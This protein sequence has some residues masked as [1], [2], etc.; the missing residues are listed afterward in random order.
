MDVDLDDARVLLRDD[1]VEDPRRFYDELRRR[2]PVWQVPGQDSYLVADPALIR[3]AVARTEEFSSNLVSLLH[4]GADGCPVAF[5]LAPLADPI[6]VLATA[7]PPIH[8]RH[9]KLL[10]AH[11]SPGAVAPLEP[12][13]R[14]IVDALLTPMVA[15]GGG[16]A[17]ALL[18]D[19]VPGQAICATVGVPLDDAPMV[20]RA[21]SD[22]GL[23]LD[24]V[25]NAED[26]EVAATAALGLSLYAHGQMEEMLGRPAADRVGLLAVL[27]AAIEAGEL[28]LDE[29]DGL[30]MQLFNAGTET[31]SSLIATAVETL[32][33]RSELQDELR[34]D[35]ARVPD[36]LEAILRDDGPFQFHY[37]WTTTDTELGGH[38]IPAGSRVLLMWAA[39][40]RP[41]GDEPASGPHYAFGRGIHFCIGAPLA[42]L[43]ARVTVERLLARTSRIVL[44]PERLPTRRPGIL[45][46][47]HA[48]LP[49]I[50]EPG[51]K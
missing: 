35:P 40:N 14:T 23:M 33:L 26:L 43:E 24:G 46:R 37:R 21:V 31:T 7:D 15:A 11:L 30:L 27:A 6:H 13:L 9:R 44:D 12:R 47:R 28:R 17:V 20:V 8:S 5:A 39:A 10:Q 41:T 2:A 25:V 34:T 42:R 48:T 1:V 38:R 50:V 49:V 29:A 18:S 22:I 51:E 19:A 3:D 32:A 45:I 36:A 4:R 16:D